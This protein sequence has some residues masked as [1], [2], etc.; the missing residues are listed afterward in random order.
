[1]KILNLYAGIG[2]NRKLWEGHEV[3]S[4]ENVDYIA[5]AYA[6]LYPDDTLIRQDAHQYLLDHYKVFERVSIFR[7]DDEYLGKVC[8]DCMKQNKLPDQVKRHART[9]QGTGVD[10]LPMSENQSTT[11]E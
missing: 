6:K 8:H 9:D 7:G 10:N 2:G 4:V 11:K 5:D 1:M 3:T